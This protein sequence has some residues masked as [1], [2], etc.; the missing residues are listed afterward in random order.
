MKA[1]TAVWIVSSMNNAYWPGSYRLA[2][3][4]LNFHTNHVYALP[5][6]KFDRD[7]TVTHVRLYNNKAQATGA[8]CVAVYE[9]VGRNAIQLRMSALV[10]MASIGHLT[11]ELTNE[12]TFRRDTQYYFAICMTGTVD[13]TGPQISVMHTDGPPLVGMVEIAANGVFPPSVTLG[14]HLEVEETHEFPAF[15]FLNKSAKDFAPEGVTEGMASYGSMYVSASATTVV[16]TTGTAVKANG[17]TVA[18][19]LKDFTMPANNRLQYTGASTKVMYVHAD[20]STSK[21]DVGTDYLELVFAKNGTAITG[22]DIRRDLAAGSVIGASS[23]SWLVSM[24]P[25]DYI[26]LFVDRENADGNDTVTVEHMTFVIH[27]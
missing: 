3:R 25:N 8:F 10:S 1:L 17:T 27:D 7:Y 16:T 6:Q 24:D 14:D 13:A 18:G 12:F 15:I 20:C 21:S 9:L 19:P 5:Y 11:Q 23:E 2:E 22:P 26:E 4:P